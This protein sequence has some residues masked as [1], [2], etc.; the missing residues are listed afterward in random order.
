MA[1]FFLVSIGVE[2]RENGVHRTVFFLFL[3]TLIELQDFW[4][5]GFSFSYICKSHFPTKIV[6]K[7][8]KRRLWEKLMENYY[9]VEY[10]EDHQ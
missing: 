3:W 2:Y 1:Y 10:R 6:D 5:E 7:K 8:K 9:L 4:T